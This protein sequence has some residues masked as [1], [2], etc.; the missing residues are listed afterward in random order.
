MPKGAPLLSTS[1]VVAVTISGPPRR[2]LSFIFPTCPVNKQP[3][4][5]N[6]V[7]TI[8]TDANKRIFSD[9]HLPKLT[10]RQ[11]DR[12]CDRESSSLRLL[13]SPA[14]RRC[15]RRRRPSPKTR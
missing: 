4:S 8:E 7:E 2:S 14:S 9:L 12:K 15:P 3:L 11:T 1:D 10:R 13:T 5:E 6:S